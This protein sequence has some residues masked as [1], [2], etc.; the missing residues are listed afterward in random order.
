[1]KKLTL[2]LIGIIGL[3]VMLCGC[4][5]TNSSAS[6]DVSTATAGAQKT[7][8]VYSC[9]GPT[10]ALQEVNKEFEKKYNCKVDFTGASAGTLR[11]A[12]ENGAYCDV[13]L[14]RST[15]HSEILTNKSLMEPDYNIYQ[16]TGWVIVT[17]KGNPKN[18]TKLEDL[19]RDDV[20]VYTNS[21]AA[22][23]EIRVLNSEKELINK[24]YEKSAK[25]FD[26]YRKMLKD[27]ADGNCDAA[28]VERRCTT[29][30]G[31]KGNVEIVEI[32]REYLKKQDCV[33]TIGVMKNSKEKDLAYKYKEFVL[34]DEGQAIL[35]KHG[36]YP[37]KS[38]KGQEILNNYYP[39]YKDLAPISQ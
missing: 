17:P 11:K 35:A 32:P 33:F 5:S 29:L 38:E 36:F 23:P 28:I 25:D 26:C 27:V 4:T 37:V 16:F 6:A 24:I 13:F 8:V 19:L 1:M 31:I 34:S 39:E 22:I 3:S 30:D 9:G 20:K 14:P 18:I 15:K 7:L 12:I 2:I 21:K 10:E